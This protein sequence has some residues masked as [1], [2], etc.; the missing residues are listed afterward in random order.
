MCQRTRWMS[1]TR[2][3]LKK[4]KKSSMSVISSHSLGTI[5]DWK[6]QKG[7]LTNKDSNPYCLITFAW[8]T[9]VNWNWIN[10]IIVKMTMMKSLRKRSNKKVDFSRL[11]LWTKGI[12]M[13][14][15][16]GYQLRIRKKMYLRMN[17]IK[18]V[19]LLKFTNL[20]LIS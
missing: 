20:M 4:I 2:N 16:T 3:L 7:S 1:I 17:N 14:F 9:V 11:S 10:I 19:F 5:Q 6:R 13:N 12:L 15:W 18:L 8:E